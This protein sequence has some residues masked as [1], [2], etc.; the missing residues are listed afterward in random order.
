MHVF[1]LTNGVA[2]ELRVSF[3]ASKT[4]LSPQEFFYG[5]F[6]GGSSVAVLFCLCVC[7]FI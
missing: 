6:Q 3:S 2:K 4:G 7:G 5:P 1:V